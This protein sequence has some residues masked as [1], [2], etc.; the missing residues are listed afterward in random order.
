MNAM[1]P[2]EDILLKILSVKK[3]EVQSAKEK[4]PEAK[5]L[6]DLTAL[7]KNSGSAPRGFAKSLQQK[8]NQGKPAV[9]AE[10]KCASPSKGLLRDPYKP[11]EIAADYE[12]HGAACLSVLTDQQFFQG[13][14]QHLIDARAACG[15]P[16]LRKD[17]MIDSY[18]VLEAR[19]WGADAILLIVAALDDAQMHDL[20]N[21]AF[22]LGMDVLIEVHDEKELDRAL[23]CKSPLIGVNNRNLRTF[24]TTL[25]TTLTLKSRIPSDRL[26]VTESGISQPADV[27]RMRDQGVNA[28]LVGEAFMR[29]PSPGA[30][31]EKLFFDS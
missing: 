1:V 23:R 7:S 29:A 17:F 10:V 21:Q 13:D 28:F 9:I 30:E 31:L 2:A 6:A 14:S 12:S 3:E 18:Q 11:S 19:L 4:L 15:L 24:E 25:Q 26:L 5:L 8:I 20:E 16:L 22:E 27:K